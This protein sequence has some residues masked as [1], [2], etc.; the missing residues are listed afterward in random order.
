MTVAFFVPGEPVAKGRARAFVRHGHVAHYT[1][2]KTWFVAWGDSDRDVLQEACNR[3]RAQYPFLYDDYVDLAEEYKLFYQR[4]RT[5][6]LKT[7]L[8]EQNLQAVGLTHSAL[9]DARNTAQLFTFLLAAGWTPRRKPERAGVLRVVRGKAQRE[10]LRPLGGDHLV[11]EIE[12]GQGH[13]SPN[14]VKVDWNLT[15]GA[16]GQRGAGGSPELP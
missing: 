15:V 4:N 9:D 10:R 5:I 8:D 13:G 12:V 14:L 16:V 2:E 1:P 6:G 7:A 3:Y 11:L